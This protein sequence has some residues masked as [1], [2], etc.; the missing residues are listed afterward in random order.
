M[1]YDLK[2][3]DGNVIK[4]QGKEMKAAENTSVL[5]SVD[6]DKR[7]LSIIASDETVDRDGDII[8]VKGWDFENYKKNPVF[9]WAHDYSSVPLA[10]AVKIAR[11]RSPWRVE[12]TH[13]FPQEGI[14]PFADMIFNLYKEKVINAGSVGFF[15]KKWKKIDVKEPEGLQ[16]GEYAHTPYNPI[17]YLEQELLEHSGCAVPAN[18]SAVQNSLKRVQDTLKNMPSYD[19]RIKGM[20]VDYFLGKSGYIVDDKK[21]STI[22]EVIGEIKEKGIE[23]EESTNIQV[24]VPEKI[25]GPEDKENKNEEALTI[26]NKK[27][28]NT[29]EMSL[30]KADDSGKE[31][32]L[33]EAI[34]FLHKEGANKT[35][36]GWLED[37]KSLKAGA[38]LNKKNME[39][40]KSAK[41]L[42]DSV[43]E[44]AGAESE[45]GEVEELG[46]ESPSGSILDQI[47]EGSFDDDTD[48][49][50]KVP[51][52]DPA[53]YDRRLEQ[54]RKQIKQLTPKVKTLEKFIKERN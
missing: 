1:A 25:E 53:K 36:I 30:P 46:L 23:I 4:F 38:V 9:L 47:L 3:K 45:D 44:D 35:L 29:N 28:A 21:A 49:N 26:E 41:S 40:L 50:P 31:M 42:I 19:D 22:L 16:H 33:D 24:Q 27:E 20:M 8:R 2:D 6:E 11:K 7:T 52:A 5:K 51:P 39:R 34:E 17:Q 10:A 32:D 43:L 18:P 15:P 12:L 13:K 54:I 37:Y 48:E 14:N